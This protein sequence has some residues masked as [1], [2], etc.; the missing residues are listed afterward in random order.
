MSRLIAATFVVPR[1]RR[2]HAGRG[3]RRPPG[4]PQPARLPAGAP[5]LVT[6]VLLP[7]AITL[8]TALQAA[9]G[10]SITAAQVVGPIAGFG[11]FGGVGSWLLV[12]LLRAMPATASAPAAAAAAAESR[13]TG[14]VPTGG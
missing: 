6:I 10:I 4:A 13:S 3:A 8:S 11:I 7:P 2:H 12:R 14:G 5:L 9:A 1:P